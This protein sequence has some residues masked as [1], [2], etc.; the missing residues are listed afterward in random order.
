LAIAPAGDLVLGHAH[1]GARAAQGLL[2]DGQCALIERLGLD[3]LA[4]GVIEGGQV[5]KA[6]SHVGMLGPEGLLPDG[7]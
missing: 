1:K 6:R 3:I 4:L 7:E 2:I 5:V